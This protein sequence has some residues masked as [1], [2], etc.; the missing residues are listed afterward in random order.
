[1]LLDELAVDVGAVGAVQVFQEGIVKNIDD[2]RVVAS[3][4][5]QPEP[6]CP[7]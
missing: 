5:I 1:M 2:Q 4:C 3:C 7:D 6:G